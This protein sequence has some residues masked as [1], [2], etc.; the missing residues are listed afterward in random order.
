[1]GSYL[2]R[3]VDAMPWRGYATIS[4]TRRRWG[5]GMAMVGGQSRRGGHVLVSDAL[6][7]EGYVQ[8]RTAR[9]RSQGVHVWWDTD[10]RAGTR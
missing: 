1:M 6:A 4:G 2:R 8:R 3:F 9:L 7:A 5:F 10:L